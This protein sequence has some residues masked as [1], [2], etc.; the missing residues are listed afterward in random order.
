M[1]HGI[2]KPTDIILSTHST[3][4]HKLADLVPNIDDETIKPLLFPIMEEETYVSVG[5][6]QIKVPNRKTLV[7]DLRG[8]SELPLDSP[9]Y[10]SE[11]QNL[12]PMHS[13]KDSYE[14][15]SNRDI[16]NG[17]LESIKDVGG[18][19]VTAG[20]LNECAKFFVSVDI[21]HSESVV[22]G[23]EYLSYLNF[24]TSHDGTL[25]AQAHDSNVRIRCWNTLVWSLAAAGQVGFKVYH[26][27]NAP[28]GMKRFPELLNAVL[29][30]RVEFKNHMEYLNSVPITFDE[31]K[32]I[33][34][35]YLKG[36]STVTDVSGH[37]INMAEEVQD[38]FKNGMGNKGQTLY[39]LFNGFTE[40]YTHGSGVGKKSQPADKYYK[41]NFGTAS[42]KKHDF[43]NFLIGMNK[44]L[45]IQKGKKFAQQFEDA[46][47]RV[48]QM[49]S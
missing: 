21:G 8:R 4:W 13:P 47:L 3:E 9:F 25:A 11:D 38:S 39:D 6:R 22:N 20:T 12:V 15:I 14:P 29:L 36:Q 40:T 43:T 44:D 5:G 23:D 33:V 28:M 19:V 16:W 48:S 10:L 31:A 24:I 17:L 41:S 37:S 1:P 18:R 7:A 42:E 26:T 46:K 30:G 49:M 2:V 32:F 45:E 34:L 27:K 35:S